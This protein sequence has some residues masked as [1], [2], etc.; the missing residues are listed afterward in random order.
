MCLLL[1][2][3]F[4]TVVVRL[5]CQEPPIIDVNLITDSSFCSAV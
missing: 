2:G 1:V 4:E 3:H 5:D